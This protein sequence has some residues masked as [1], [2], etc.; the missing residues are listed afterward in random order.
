MRKVYPLMRLLHAKSGS[1]LLVLAFAFAPVLCCCAVK[2]AAAAMAT[3]K[4]TAHD[5]CDEQPQPAQPSRHHEDP[6]GCGGRISLVEP[7]N[8]AL[9]TAPSDTHLLPV[10]AFIDVA[11]GFHAD[12][13]DP[14]GVWAIDR[15][16]PPIPN[17]LFAHHCLLTT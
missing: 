2:Q 3:H 11:F 5:C 16:P 8:A 14:Y 4:S 10:A 15:H 6:C 12:A 1:A 13:S 17:S 9:W 7:N